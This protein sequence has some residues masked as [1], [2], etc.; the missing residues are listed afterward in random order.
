M[1]K[2]FWRM[3]GQGWRGGRRS[4]SIG[5]PLIC[6][7][8]RRKKIKPWD[9][10]NYFPLLWSVRGVYFSFIFWTSGVMKSNARGIWQRSSVPSLTHLARIIF[11]Y[12]RMIKI[13][14]STGSS[15][16]RRHSSVWGCLDYRLHSKAIVDKK[17]EVNLC[18]VLN[19]TSFHAKIDIQ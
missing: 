8:D 13:M 18:S 11:D 16:I 2:P 7:T 9:S 1:Q 6:T 19:H 12:I 3:D 15:S 17:V 4:R 5:E 14:M 10:S